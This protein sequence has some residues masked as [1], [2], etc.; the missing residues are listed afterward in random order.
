MIENST[1][2]NAEKNESPDEGAF[3][4]WLPAGLTLT[5]IGALTLLTPLFT[6][7]DARGFMIDMISGAILM[8]AGMAAIVR[9]K[10]QTH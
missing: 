8:I 10:A 4:V 5:G 1:N 3:K 2:T 7:L 9:S 6:Q